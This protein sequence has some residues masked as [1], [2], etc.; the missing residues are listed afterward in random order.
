MKHFIPKNAMDNAE[1]A[2]RVE[3]IK[4]NRE[5]KEQ[6][7]PYLTL[8]EQQEIINASSQKD[9]SKQKQ[10]TKEDLSKKFGI[11]NEALTSLLAMFSTKRQEAIAKASQK[12]TQIILQFKDK[13]PPKLGQKPEESS[14]RFSQLTVHY[15]KVPWDIY[16]DIQRLQ[17][18][19]ADLNKIKQMTLNQMAEDG[20]RVK[21][22]VLSKNNPSITGLSD[23]EFIK[24]NRII[25]EKQAKL[26]QLAGLWMY[27]I[28]EADT[29]K[30]ETLT[31]SL[32]VEAGLY[33]L[34][35][36]FPTENPNSTSYLK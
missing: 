19:V 29:M 18:E 13:S 30:C 25:A 5:R 36:G 8:T 33:R 16:E 34:Q 3:I 28:P 31:L 32:A 6:G 24:L 14:D 15:N 17:G 7:L 10:E 35:F 4:T 27:G 23:V 2:A 20:T 21:E 9:N 26:Y 1:V 22:P 12:E 11:S